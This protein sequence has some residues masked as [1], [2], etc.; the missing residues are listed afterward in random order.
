MAPAWCACTAEFR[1]CESWMSWMQVLWN[2]VNWLISSINLSPWAFSTAA[3]GG[4][5]GVQASGEVASEVTANL[6]AYCNAVLS[7]HDCACQ[8]QRTQSSVLPI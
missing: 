7:A 1:G 2:K 3:Q 6:L 4:T 8:M 5:G